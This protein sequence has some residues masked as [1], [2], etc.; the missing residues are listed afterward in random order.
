MKTVKEKIAG[1]LYCVLQAIVG[2][3]LLIN[4][5]A[6]TS[7]IIIAIG[8]LLI[9]V[10]IVGVIQYF[11][12]PADEAAKGQALTKGLLTVTLGVFC[13]CGSNWLIITFPIAAIVYGIIMLVIGVSKIQLAVDAVRRKE[14]KWY[15]GIISALITLAGGSIVILNPFTTT[16]ALWLFTGIAFVVDAVFDLAAIILA[17]KSD[18]T[19]DEETEDGED[20]E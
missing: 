8:A 10:G 16:A 20:E 17:K 18:D 2:V 11:R 14:K 1:V 19:E 7:G 5:V 3:L 9:V 12:T 6:F 15:W 13:A 4:P